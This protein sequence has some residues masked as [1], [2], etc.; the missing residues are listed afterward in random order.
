MKN[1]NVTN[2]KFNKALYTLLAGIFATSASATSFDNIEVM[3][4]E[5]TN[6]YL[7]MNQAKAEL[8]TSIKD[9]Q[10]TTVSTQSSAQ[11]LL[12][13]QAEEFNQHITL[14]K[15]TLMAE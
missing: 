12:T 1:T 2:K 10:L 13:A 6:H 11:Q 14:A 5:T 9:M 15:V 4:I 8:A 3:E 7:I